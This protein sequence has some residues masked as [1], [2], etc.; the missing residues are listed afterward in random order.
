MREE[1]ERTKSHSFGRVGIAQV[2]IGI[3]DIQVPKKTLRKYSGD[4]TDGAEQYA[5]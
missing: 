1:R 3:E 5:A 4:R 2:P